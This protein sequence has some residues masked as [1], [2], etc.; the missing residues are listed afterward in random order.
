[1]PEQSGDVER[2]KRHVKSDERA[3]E[4]RLAPALV[5]PETEGLREPVNDAGEAREHHAADD[6]IVKM[7]NEEEAVVELEIRRGTASSIPV[8][9]PMTKVTRK[10]SD[11][12]IGVLKRIRPPYIV[13]SPV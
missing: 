4:H 6:N 8:M 9:P 7:S 13:N 3:P 11:H 1:M 2:K 5:Q 10:P 12:S